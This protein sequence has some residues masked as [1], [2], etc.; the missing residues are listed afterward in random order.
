MQ[1]GTGLEMDALLIPAALLAVIALL[2]VLVLLRRVSAAA[3][4]RR[5]ERDISR[6]RAS[7]HAKREDLRR[8]LEQELPQPQAIQ[9]DEVYVDDDHR[10]WERDRHIGDTQPMDTDA[11]R[12]LR[13]AGGG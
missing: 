7:A 10:D 13:K 5:L 1:E 4:E 6:E 11:L 9:V 2:L 3:R 8:K 12:R